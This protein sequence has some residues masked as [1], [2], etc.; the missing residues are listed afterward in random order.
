MHMVVIQSN[1]TALP[2]S[3]LL[4]CLE[5]SVFH[6]YCYV[7]ICFSI[8]VIVVVLYW[9]QMCFLIVSSTQ[10][11]ENTEIRNTFQYNAFFFWDVSVINA[12]QYK[13]SSVQKTVNIHQ[14]VFYLFYFVWMHFA[15]VIWYCWYGTGAYLQHYK[16]I[17]M[18]WNYVGYILQS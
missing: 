7:I 10:K 11:S 15:Y 5:C 4:W 17:H 13:P 2:W 9:I 1:T 14:N 12:V 18:C 6:F 16:I 3:L 8:E